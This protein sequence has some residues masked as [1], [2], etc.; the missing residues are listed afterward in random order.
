MHGND[1]LDV[2]VDLRDRGEAHA[3]A[4]VVETE[5][6]VSAEKGAKAV[7]DAQGRTVAGWVGGGCAD[8]SAGQ[9]AREALADGQG[10][11][12]EIDMTDEILGA[13]VPCG[14]TMKVWVDPVRPRP[15]A[16]LLGQGRLVESLCRMATICG[17]DVVINDPRATQ[18]RYP[19]AVRLDTDD[20]EYQRLTPGAEDCVVVATQHKGDHHSVSRALA[21]GA[22]YIAL[23]ASRKRARLVL[24]SL[25]DEGFTPEQL[26]RVT[27][28]AGLD[29]GGR[30]P[31][32]IALAILSEM[33]LLHYGGSG[34]R[35]CEVKPLEPL[36]G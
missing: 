29:L 30:A 13:G 20:M 36:H 22:G 27:A 34:R 6:S 31:E 7:F 9:A 19:D 5:G 8:S 33:T 10:R 18:E 23:V 25:R 28:P 26:R 3:V 15:T 32:E 2:L 4:T 35:L 1:L 21:Q 14:G 24:D 12:I 11:L 17:F 16:W